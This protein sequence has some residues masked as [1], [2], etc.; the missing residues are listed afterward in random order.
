MGW[1]PNQYDCCL[2]KKG[3]F[4]PDKCHRENHVKM[5]AEAGVMLLEAKECQRLH[6]NHQRFQRA[7]SDSPLASEGNNSTG[8]LTLD[9]QVTGHGDDECPRFLAS[10]TEVIHFCS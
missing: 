6:A 1:A 4:G 8:T 3:T 7:L 10:I 5:E 9:S 2:H